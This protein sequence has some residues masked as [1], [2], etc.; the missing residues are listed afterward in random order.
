MVLTLNTASYWKPIK[1]IEISE[2][3]YTESAN[4]SFPTLLFAKKSLSFH[5]T[6]IA[7]IN[8]LIVTKDTFNNEW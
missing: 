7:N 4:N 5:H 6:F 8:K 3:T 1:G 2:G